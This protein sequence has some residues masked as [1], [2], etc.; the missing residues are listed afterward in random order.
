MPPG[1]LAGVAGNVE[2]LLTEVGKPLVARLRGA[3]M[4]SSVGTVRW[5]VP[6]RH[7]EDLVGRQLD[8]EPVCR[9]KLEPPS[10]QIVSEAMG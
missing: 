5:E 4:G 6:A 10:L 3:E 8:G 2:L 9:Y 7:Q 1:V